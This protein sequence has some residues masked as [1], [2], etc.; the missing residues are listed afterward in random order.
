MILFLDFDGV[1]HPLSRENGTFSLCSLFESVMHEASNVDI[2]VSSAW[3]ESQT[4]DDLRSHFSMNVRERIIDTTPVFSHLAHPYLRQAEISA[5]MRD[6]GREYESW[7]ALDDSDWL[8][9]P[10]CRNLI[11]VNGQVGLDRET[12]ARLL[13]AIRN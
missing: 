13:R 4:L 10:G 6:A 5:W 2:V 9:S 11:L 8:F 12:A 3:R 1:L 7:I